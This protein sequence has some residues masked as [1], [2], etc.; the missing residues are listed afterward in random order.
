MLKKNSDN[1]AEKMGLDMEEELGVKQVEKAE[2]KAEKQQKT[3]KIGN[4]QVYNMLT[5]NELSWQA[6]IYDLI[7]TEQLDPWDIDLA[8]IAKKYLEKIRAL[9]EANFFISSKVLLAASLLLR[10]KS[11]ILLN[12]YIRS[13]DDILFGRKEEEKKQIELVELNEEIPGLF[14]RTP[15]PR[16]RKVTLQ[17]L[18]TALNKAIKTETRRIDREIDIKRAKREAE[19]VFPRTRVNIKDRIK[20]IYS[21]V[22]TLFKAKK[23]RLAYSEL[24]GGNREDRIFSFLPILHLDTQ[25]KVW[26]EQEKHFDEIWVWLYSHYVRNQKISEHPKNN[27]NCF[28]DKK[29]NAEKFAAELLETEKEEL[30]EIKKE[31][32]LGNVTGF[33]NLIEGVVEEEL[34]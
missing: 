20:K 14:T 22:L 31:E 34:E 28:F 25:K 21:R 4:E 26:L 3:D 24:V 9:E 10:I 8:L 33:D 27:Q 2:N 7:N 23:T 12:E 13:L 15:I 18:M 32:E 30:D 5:N 19:A 1:K 6:I 16:M 17:E 29:E 11:E